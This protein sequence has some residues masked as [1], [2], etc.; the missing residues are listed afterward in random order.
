MIA[1]VLLYVNKDDCF[2]DSIAVIIIFYWRSE[3]DKG[4]HGVLELRV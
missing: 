1:L 4:Q 3:L 2:V